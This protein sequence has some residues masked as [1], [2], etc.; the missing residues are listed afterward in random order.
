MAA[1]LDQDLN[2]I[3]ADA[4]WW[5]VH[6]GYSP[7]LATAIHNGHEVRSDLERTDGDLP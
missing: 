5:T 4:D 3:V 2:L 6:C 7:I 1:Q